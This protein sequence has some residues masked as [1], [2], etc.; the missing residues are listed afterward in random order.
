MPGSCAQHSQ[1]LEALFAHV[2]GLQVALPATVQDAYDLLLTAIR[3]D[4]PT[5][6]IENR[7]LYHGE[8]TEITIGGP[9]QPVGSAVLRRDG[10]DLTIVTWGAM[11][12]QAL[13]AE[14]TLAEE[15]VSAQVLDLRWVRPLDVDTLLASVASTR[16]LVVA[17]EAHRY[18]GVGAEVVATVVEEGIPLLGPPVR[19][20]M[21]DVRVPAAP[22]LQAEVVPSAV[23]IV[24]A[25]RRAMAACVA[26]S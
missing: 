14:E 7:N 16:R 26:A 22:S 6:V 2:P 10:T 24:D 9:A 13:L 8:K 4:D 25:A 15:G 11:V 5:I 19:V 20:G 1:N 17:H 21:P 18:G 12:H 23:S 3:S